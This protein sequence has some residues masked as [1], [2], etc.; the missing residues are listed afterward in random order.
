VDEEVVGAEV[1]AGEP[2]GPGADVGVEPAEVL[3]LVP[4]RLAGLAPAL[5]MRSA[6]CI[7]W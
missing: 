6:S 1:A 3:V 7:I 5:R 4:E 2:F